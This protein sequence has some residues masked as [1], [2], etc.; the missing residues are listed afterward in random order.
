MYL[1]AKIV[2]FLVISSENKKSIILTAALVRLEQTFFL[3][4]FLPA[5][6]QNRMNLNTNYK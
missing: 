2:K 5:Q 3:A 1:V 4:A 6:G